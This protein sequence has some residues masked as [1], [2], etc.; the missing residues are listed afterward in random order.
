MDNMLLGLQYMFADPY[1][2][3]L[4]FAA[5]F[6]GLFFGAIPGV[7]ITTL[8]AILLPFTAYLTT[9]QALMVYGVMYCSGTYGGAVMA[10]LFNIPGAAEN[11]PTAFD[12]YPLT[13]QGKAGLAIGAAVTCSAI[14]GIL[15]CIGMMLGTD[16]IARWAITSFGPPEMFA[17][18]LCGI[19][20]ASTMGTS[21]TLKGLISIC[22]GLLLATVGSDPVGGIFRFTYGS[23]GLSGGI[24]FIPLL[25]GFF[26]VSEVF[27]HSGNA[28]SSKQLN[29]Y[30]NVTVQFPSLKT[31]WQQRVNI[32][33]SAGCGFC[34]GMLPGLGATLA[35]FMSYGF[36]RSTSKHPE[37]FGKGELSGVIASETGNNA[38][39]GGAMIPMLALGLPGGS[40][41]ALM[42]SVFLLHGLEP[43]PLVMTQQTQMVWAVFM[44]MFLANVSILFLGYI[45]SCTVVNLLKIPTSFLMPIIF[46]LACIGT[47]ALRNSTFDV[48]IML[49][50]GLFGFILKR[51]D[52]SAAGIVLGSI[53]GTLGEAAFAKTMQMSDYNYMI[54][55]ER[56][57]C[58]FFILVSV[59]SLCAILYRALKESFK[60]N[61]QGGV[62]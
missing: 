41:T 33:R 45:T 25:L 43:G 26:S 51:H 13:R 24:S 7:S 47:Y 20:L 60:K 46:V 21:S 55:L 16:M 6:G 59:V 19:V 34:C 52:Y 36:A 15:S 27:A 49:V 35:A 2:I 18:I 32:F 57:F 5:L 8:G 17:V 54:F 12:G 53:L 4:F 30:R 42:L 58:A 29:E 40:T 22:L 38:A 56:P 11:A 23:V 28:V 14:G 61:T 62:A 37:N 39:T 3:L 48:G 10:I 1:N 9:A 31:F 50:A 44:A